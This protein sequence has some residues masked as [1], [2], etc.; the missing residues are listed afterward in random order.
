MKAKSSL[1]RNVTAISPN[2]EMV[3]IAE[4]KPAAVRV[5]V[6][7]KA[8]LQSLMRSLERF[9]Q[10][11]PIVVND[12]GVIVHG[13]ARFEAAS[14]LGWINISTIRVQ[15]LNDD[16]L[17]VY[18][19]AANKLVLDAGWDLSALRLELEAIEAT[20]PDFDMSL[21]G[22]SIPEIDT[23]RGAYEASSL[24]DL[25]DDVPEVPPNAEPTSR[26]GDI[27]I[28]GEH[29]LL[30]GNALDAEAVAELMAEDCAEL[31]FSDP[32]YNV[33]IDGHVSGL[34]KVRH[35]EFAM[36][37]G[38]MSPEEFVRFLVDALSN[39]ANHLINGGLA[40]VCM[41]HGH[42]GE[43][44]DAGAKVFD[45]RK[46]ICVWDKGSGGMGSLYRNAHELIAVFKKGTAPHFN[47]VELGQHGRNRT[48]VWRY[49]GIAKAGVGR[50]KA[51][52]LHPTVKPVALVADVLLDASSRG[53]LVL[54]PFG[55][56]GTTLIAAQIKRRRARL[57]ELDPIYADTIVARFETLTGAQAI[58]AS[59]NLSFA[60]VRALRLGDPRQP[61]HSDNGD[62]NVDK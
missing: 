43:L 20:T 41:D 7:S 40:Y 23:L 58:H 45:E 5:R 14:R 42:I 31:I 54:D 16:D 32:P 46:S 3:P 29:K 38:E 39:S 21:T 37:S 56:S 11:E 49:P 8:K 6:H 22:F 19:I 15:H 60:D 12:R 25:V 55:G 53:G 34:G 4:L 36:A 18:A 24:N 30:C 2:I 50:S 9:G 51:L 28:L 61:H 44:I 35:R 26:L 57:I 62:K 52:E 27:W 59:E 1:R 10:I 48:T 17:R 47:N 13:H 33:P